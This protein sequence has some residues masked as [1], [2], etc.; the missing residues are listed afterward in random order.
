MSPK[1]LTILS[2]VTLI[3]LNLLDTFFTV[4]YINFGPLDESN[5]LMNFL[6]EQDFRLFIFFKIFVPTLLIFFLL[7]NS[8]HRFIRFSLYLLTLFYSSLI[9]WW[10]LVI[11]LI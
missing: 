10:I 7:A 9:M 5:P 8:H 3:V 11:L 2:S 1:K 4:K 6:L